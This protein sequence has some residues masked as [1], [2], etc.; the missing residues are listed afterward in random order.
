M[1]KTFWVK[2]FY[3]CLAATGKQLPH[4]VLLVV[5][6]VLKTERITPSEGGKE[7]KDDNN[8]RGSRDAIRMCG[9]ESF[10]ANVQYVLGRQ[11]WPWLFLDNVIFYFLVD[12]TQDYME[13]CDSYPWIRR[14][15]SMSIML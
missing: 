14:S 8:E 15:P 1:E 6:F 11:W 13:E 10:K 12:V 5:N 3:S 9:S 7:Q 4:Y 2:L